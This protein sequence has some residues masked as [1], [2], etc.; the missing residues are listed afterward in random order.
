MCLEVSIELKC[1]KFFVI[2]ERSLGLLRRML[3]HDGDL[4]SIQRRLTLN[5]HRRFS[6]KMG[7]SDWQVFLTCLP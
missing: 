3:Q 6:F 1:I 7:L 5:R 2:V 4:K